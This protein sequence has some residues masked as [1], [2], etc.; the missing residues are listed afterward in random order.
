P[1]LS[2]LRHRGGKLQPPQMPTRRIQPPAN[3]SA[4]K[5][6]ARSRSDES[7]QFLSQVSILRRSDSSLDRACR[8]ERNSQRS[9]CTSTESTAGRSRTIGAQ[10]SPA[11]GDAYTC[12]PVVP[13]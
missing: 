12:P 10:L 7:F 6:T 11:S 5:A 4:R 9:V 1:P 3:C 8:N 2:R 13:K